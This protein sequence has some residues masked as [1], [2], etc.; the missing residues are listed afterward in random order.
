[1]EMYVLVHY[2]LS[3][4]SIL[5]KMVHD[6]LL[7]TAPSFYAH[8]VNGVFLL[9]SVVFIFT[10]SSKL[11]ALDPYHILFLLLLF[12][13]AVGFHGLLHL[14]LENNYGYNPIRILFS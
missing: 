5:D 10:H 13:I 2:L 7:I 14:G 11:K 6:N 9:I 1:M 12:G 3:D 8:I 4:I